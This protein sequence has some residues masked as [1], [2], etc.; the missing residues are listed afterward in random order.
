MSEPQLV[1]DQKID[2]PFKYTIGA[3]QRAFLRG[4]TEGKLLA[5]TGGGE[6]YVPADHADRN[7]AQ[8][9]AAWL[10]HVDLDPERVHAM[11]ASDEEYVG[12][13]D[14]AA[15]YA[16]VVR[17]HGRGRFDLVMLGIGPDGHVASLFP[18]RA[19]LDVDDAVTVAVS[20][21]PKP[22]PQRVSLTFGALNRNRQ[23]WFIASGEGK[24]DAVARALRG[25]DV[26]EIPAAGVH[27]SE[28]T[29]WWLDASAASRLT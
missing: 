3:A 15:A 20:D 29:V 16:D 6:R 7:A 11:P 21:S 19:H 2:L 8:A 10:S 27:G 22:P 13:H 24:A 25:D 17:E 26:H 18:G 28:R 12:V 23:V 9:R 14:A 5:S 4:L 1:F